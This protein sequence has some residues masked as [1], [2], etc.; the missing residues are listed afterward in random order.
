MEKLTNRQKF[1][2][3][4]LKKFMANNGYAPTVRDL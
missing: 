3:D 4:N 1:V 2:L